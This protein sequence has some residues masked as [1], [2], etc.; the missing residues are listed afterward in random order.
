[1]ETRPPDGRT[2][3]LASTNWA[4][5]GRGDVEHLVR[6]Y[7]KP[8]FRFLRRSLS[9]DDQAEEVT[10]EFFLRFIEK[11]VLARLDPARGRFRDFLFHMAR[12]FLID[13][14]RV[15]GA[16]KRYSGSRPI[17]LD[18]APEVESGERDPREEFDRQWFLSLLNRARRELKAHYATRERPE[19][20]QAFRLFYFGSREPERWSQKRI[21][22]ELGLTQAQVNNHLHRAKGVYA[23]ILQDLVAEYCRGEEEV[24]EEIRDIARFLDSS[25]IEGPEASTLVL[26]LSG[27]RGLQR[28]TIVEDGPGEGA[29]GA[30][31]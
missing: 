18:Q 15:R 7:W 24:R 4:A 17:P 27:H 10:Q 5:L 16:A 20:Y 1:M 29:P 14:Y 30:R 31:P 28:D 13:H 2:D 11:N 19:V 21:A 12:E 25:R 22:E 6:Y 9:T 3:R 23:R 8:V 26:L